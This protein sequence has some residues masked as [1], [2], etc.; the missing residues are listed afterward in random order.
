M[1][2]CRP[3][4]SNH[5]ID[6]DLRV[7]DL[8]DRDKRHWNKEKLEDLFFPEDIDR[9]LQTRPVINKDDFLDLGS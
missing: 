4:I 2:A 6:I 7:C 8:I 5:I 3:L 1:Y 9:I